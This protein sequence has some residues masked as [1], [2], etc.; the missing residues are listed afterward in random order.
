MAKSTGRTLDEWM[1]RIGRT[2]D[3]ARK[4]IEKHYNCEPAELTVIRPKNP[5]RAPTEREFS[6]IN[7]LCVEYDYGYA[8]P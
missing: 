3:A 5:E 7:F 2:H 4:V 6:A 8:S 1:D